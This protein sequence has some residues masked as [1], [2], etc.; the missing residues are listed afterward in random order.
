MLVSQGLCQGYR[1]QHTPGPAVT[2][3]FQSQYLS[4]KKDNLGAG[5]VAW[6]RKASASQALA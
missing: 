6:R 3:S 1:Y 4:R 2:D 5:E